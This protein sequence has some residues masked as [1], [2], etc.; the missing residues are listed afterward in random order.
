MLVVTLEYWPASDPSRSEPRGWAAVLRGYHDGKDAWVVVVT[1]EGAR[2]S[3][4]GPFTGTALGALCAALSAIGALTTPASASAE[5]S[6]QHP[7]PLSVVHDISA[8]VEPALAGTPAPPANPPG[9]GRAARPRQAPQRTG[10]RDRVLDLPMLTERQVQDLFNGQRDH[11]AIVRGLRKAGVII[12]LPYGDERLFPSF[13][14]SSS[15]LDPIV[16]AT[17]LAIAAE[18]D[19][20]RAAMWWTTPNPALGCPPLDL[21]YRPGEHD[22]LLNAARAQGRRREP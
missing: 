21:L 16:A 11:P 12:G 18:R 10:A 15:R 20:W 5:S 6:S 17:N 14:F 22:R 2:N 4:T 8:V 9:A 7:A 13:Q 3:W 1:L 19:H